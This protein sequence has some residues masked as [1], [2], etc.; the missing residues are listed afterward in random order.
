MIEEKK[1]EEKYEQLQYFEKTIDFEGDPIFLASQIVEFCDFKNYFIYEKKEELSLALGIY[2]LLL[3]DSE[4][5]TLKVDNKISHLKNEI[6]SKAINRAF[7]SILVKNWRAYGIANYGLARYNYSLPLLSEEKELLKLFIPKVEVRFLNNSIFLRALEENELENIEKSIRKILSNSEFEISLKKRVDAQKLKIQEIYLC[8]KEKYIKIVTEAIKE[9]N[10]YK[11]QKVVLSRKIP[12]KYELDMVASYVAGRKVNSPERSYCLQLDDLNVVGF[13][14]E[15]VVEVDRN[16]WVSTLPLAGTRST[17]SSKEEKAKL[18][19]ELLNNKK[20]ILEHLSTVKFT[21]EEV[22][23]ICDSETVSISDFMSVLDRGTV[24]HISSRVKGKLKEG[25]SSWHAFNSLFPA[26][27]SSGVPKKES[28]DAIGRFEKNPRNLFGGCVMIYDSNGEMDS[29]LVLR[30]IFQKDNK[31][32]LQ[33]GAGIGAMSD[34]SREFEE[35][36]EKISSVSN[37][38]VM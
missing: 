26:G 14:P 17:G 25:Y 16:G 22:K 28:I 1:L 20:E 23:K 9:I 12:L 34:P 5:T 3:V 24:Q 21:Y 8:E 31:F 32:W 38:L 19:H 6:L 30:T 18:K 36:C 11:Y 10:E 29:A 2:A 35:T 7:S 37:Q 13:S 33:V 27:T 15:T 4:Y